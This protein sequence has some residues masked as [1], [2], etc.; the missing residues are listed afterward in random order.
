[1]I[2]FRPSLLCGIVVAMMASAAVLAQI[3]AAKPATPVAKAKKASIYDKAADAKVQVAKAARR[4]KQDDKRIL[5]MFGGDWCG[6][7][8]KLHDLFARTPRVRKPLATNMC[9]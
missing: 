7:C 3:E 1:M 2:C 9:W 6:W 4:A 8:H 5:L